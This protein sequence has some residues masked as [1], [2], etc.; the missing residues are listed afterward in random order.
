MR[1]QPT[2]AAAKLLVQDGSENVYS[3]GR[4]FPKKC[5][6]V[7]G[8]SWDG[9]FRPITSPYLCTYVMEEFR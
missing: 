6:Q 5:Q 4:K 8:G 1:L 7:R 9:G 3:N 2:A